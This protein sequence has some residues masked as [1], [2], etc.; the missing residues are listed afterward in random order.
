MKNKIRK[1][2]QTSLINIKGAGRPAVHDPGI[3][4]TE[5]PVLT[6]SASL[7]LTVKIKRIKADLKNKS[8]LS[9]LKKAILNT[10]K[11]GLRVIH[12][13]LEFD[14]VHLL[15]E[16]ENNLILAK[17]MQSFGVTFS[18]AINRLRKL[19][20][21][22]YKHRYH[23]RRIVGARQLKNVLNYIFSNG[24]KHKTAKTIVNPYNS[25]KAEKRYR[26]FFRGKIDL[27]SELMCLLDSGRIF[28]RSLDFM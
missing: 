7:H 14:H 25:I 9:I 6:K 17:G 16:A 21:G 28:F 10:R 3:R 19:K 27:D 8:I 2:Q 1:N 23:F 26:L 4:H 24:V 5:R 22:V 12:Y 18:K 11:Q 15:I 20:G 13:S